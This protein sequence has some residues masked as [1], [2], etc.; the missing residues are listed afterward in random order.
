[1]YIY[2]CLKKTHNNNQKPRGVD[3]NIFL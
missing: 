1:M 2:T 3:T